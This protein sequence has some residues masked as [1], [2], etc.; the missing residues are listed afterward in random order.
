MIGDIVGDIQISSMIYMIKKSY[1]VD[2]ICYW[3]AWLSIFKAKAPLSLIR[4]IHWVIEYEYVWCLLS[5]I[6]Y[7]SPC[8]L[9]LVIWYS[10]VFVTWYSLYYY[11]H[12]LILAIT[13]KKNNSS[14]SCSAT[15]SCFLLASMD[16][17]HLFENTSKTGFLEHPVRTIKS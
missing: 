17:C 1:I 6:C 11:S 13:C 9:L 2:V 10:L 5:I 3:H 16:D 14:C 12:N 15:R 8:Y 4:K 7:L